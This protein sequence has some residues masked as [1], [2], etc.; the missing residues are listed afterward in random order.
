MVDIDTKYGHGA[1]KITHKT[2]NQAMDDVAQAL[3]HKNVK[4]A[5]LH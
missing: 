1:D 4:L 2:L 3:G 5:P